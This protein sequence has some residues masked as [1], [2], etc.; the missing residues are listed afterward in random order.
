MDWTHLEYFLSVA[1]IGWLS[2]ATKQ[3]R[4]NHSTVA[5]RLDQQGTGKLT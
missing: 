5:R 2:G 3:M 4:V 1:F